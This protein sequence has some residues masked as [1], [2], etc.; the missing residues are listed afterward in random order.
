MKLQVAIDIAGAQHWELNSD[1]ADAEF[2][3][4]LLRV[5]GYNTWILV[6]RPNHLERGSLGTSCEL[7]SDRQA[8]N[9]LLD[10]LIR[11]PDD[12]CSKFPEIEDYIQ[13]ELWIERM[14]LELA[15]ELDSADGVDIS[16]SPPSDSPNASDSECAPIVEAGHSSAVEANLPVAPSKAENTKVLD[17]SGSSD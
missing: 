13:T 12:I 3:R 7:V 15:F 17:I 11:P 5:P 6:E 8:A 9:L 1:D 4:E 2:R 14:N 10:S 16:D